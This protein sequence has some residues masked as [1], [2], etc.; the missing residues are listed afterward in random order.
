[1]REGGGGCLLFQRAVLIA[2]EAHFHHV[3]RG[4][5]GG[6]VLNSSMCNEGI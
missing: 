1:M 4:Q 5:I 3:L 6:C 2:P